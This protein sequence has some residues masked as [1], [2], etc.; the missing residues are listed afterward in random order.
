MID[1]RPGHYLLCHSS[2]YVEICSQK[3]EDFTCISYRAQ[4]IVDLAPSSLAYN[5]FDMSPSSLSE[6]I[7]ASQEQIIRF[8]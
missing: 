2:P 1:S 5:P 4:N 6:L 3:H 7:L 8:L